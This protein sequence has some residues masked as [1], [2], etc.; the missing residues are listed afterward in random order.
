MEDR[1][2]HPYGG[3]EYL[4]VPFSL[5]NAVFQFLINDIIHYYLNSFM[6]VYLDD[7]LICSQIV[8]RHYIC[9]VLQRLLENKLYVKAEKCKFHTSSSSKVLAVSDWPT[10]VLLQDLQRFLSFANF[11]RRKL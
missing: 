7:I 4:V 9:Q 8:D 1:L 2:Q 11:H 3:Y 10:S 6:S 5:T